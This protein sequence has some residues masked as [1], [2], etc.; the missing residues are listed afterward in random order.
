MHTATRFVLAVKNAFIKGLSS[1]C[2][3]A[4]KRHGAESLSTL[5]C[6][7]VIPCHLPSGTGFL[8]RQ[9]SADRFG[10]PEE[11]FSAIRFSSHSLIR[12]AEGEGPNILVGIRRSVSRYA[13]GRIATFSGDRTQSRRAVRELW[14]R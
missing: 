11:L 10:L 9:A 8:Y 12:K 2:N 6:A 4:A 5:L 1:S 7:G 3:R 13:L 14:V